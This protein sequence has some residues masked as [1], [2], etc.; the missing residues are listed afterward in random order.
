MWNYGTMAVISFIAGTIFWFQFRH[1]DA[2][3]DQLNAL[4]TGHVD[5]KDETL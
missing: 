3:E 4:G 1:L 2:Q 5:E